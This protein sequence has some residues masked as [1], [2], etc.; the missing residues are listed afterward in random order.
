VALFT[1]TRLDGIPRATP[2]LHAL[3]LAAGLITARI[4]A[5][6][7][8]ENGTTADAKTTNGTATVGSENI[9]MVGAT[10][11]TSLY[12]KLLGACSQ[13]QRRILAILDD[14]TQS[15]GR[16]MAGVR[17][18]ATTEQLECIIDEFVV[19]GLQTDRVIVGGEADLLSDSG[20]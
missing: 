6:V 4:I 17:I 1:F 10:Q 16:S 18:L 7:F 3:I 13:G 20:L 8:D 15:T 2:L 5:R 12:I 9:I 11:L 19:H 14:R